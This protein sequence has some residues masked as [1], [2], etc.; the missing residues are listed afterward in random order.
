LTDAETVI[1]TIKDR[2]SS[3]L[4]RLNDLISFLI[5]ESKKKVGYSGPRKIVVIR[6]TEGNLL[7]EIKVHSDA[8]LALSRY[9]GL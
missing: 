6:D 2:R 5:E 4:R 9:N 3:T 7:S 1:Y 8:F